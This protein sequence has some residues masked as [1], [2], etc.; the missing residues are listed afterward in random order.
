VPATRAIQ[1]YAS[2]RTEVIDEQDLYLLSCTRALVPAC[3]EIRTLR[4]ED[5]AASRGL[6]QRRAELPAVSER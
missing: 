2:W 5:E 6:S 4:G 1:R 3:C